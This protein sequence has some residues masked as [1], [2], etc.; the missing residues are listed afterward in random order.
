MKCRNRDVI[1]NETA[2]KL[3]ETL[4]ESQLQAYSQEDF[5]SAC[6]AWAPTWNDAS[7]AG[8]QRLQ[9]SGHTETPKSYPDGYDLD[10]VCEC[11]G[12]RMCT[13]E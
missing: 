4:L 6:V 2:R 12:N 13:R 11:C 1:R 7:R 9:E 10:E 5:V 3:Q 8:V